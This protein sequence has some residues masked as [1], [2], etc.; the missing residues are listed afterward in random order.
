MMQKRMRK[1][2]SAEA[3]MKPPVFHGPT[4]ADVTLVCWGS[5]TGQCREAADEINNE[6]GSANLLQFIDLWPMPV[7]P[8]EHALRS[9]KKTVAVEQNFTGQLAQLIRMTT[10]VQVAVCYVRYDGRPFSPVRSSWRRRDGDPWPLT[11][12]QHRP[13]HLAIRHHLVR[14]VR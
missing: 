13:E 14:R 9:C 12:A 1:L 10:G 2:E 8:A 5:T 3:E 6:G 4:N 11:S 7:G